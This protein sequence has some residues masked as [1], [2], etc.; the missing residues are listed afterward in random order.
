MPLKKH[1]HRW[2]LCFFHVL[3]QVCIYAIRVMSPTSGLVGFVQQK[4]PGG[5]F[6]QTMSPKVRAAQAGGGEEP[7]HTTATGA[8]R[9][10]EVVGSPTAYATMVCDQFRYARRNP[11]TTT[12][13]GFF[14]A[15]FE[16]AKKRYLLLKADDLGELN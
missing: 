16:V 4:H 9:Y 8:K 5:M 2:W 10:P 6:L 7:R 13:S 14:R 15:L 1:N 11:E 12:V 3:K